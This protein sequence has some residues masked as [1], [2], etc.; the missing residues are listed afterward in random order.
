M[1]YQIQQE[2]G[3]HVIV[4]S[5]FFQKKR[6]YENEGER[7]NEDECYHHC[8]FS[9]V[10]YRM[11]LKTFHNLNFNGKISLIFPGF[12]RLCVLCQIINAYNNKK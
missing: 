10:R 2:E 7:R 3:C 6:L 12:S 11:F 5:I 1:G 8:N 9:F 4:R